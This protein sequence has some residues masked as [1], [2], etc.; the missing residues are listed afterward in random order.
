[1]YPLSMRRSMRLLDVSPRAVFPPRSGAGVRIYNLL[2][3]LGRR[4]EVRG[5]SHAWSGRLL[6]RPSVDEVR[7]SP[8]YREYRY[9]HPATRLAGEVAKGTWLG[10][11]PMSGIG[12]HVARPRCL[13]SLLEWAELTLVEFPWQF[14][15]CR[16][17]RPRG[18]LV[19]A[20]H[21]VERRKFPSWA[22]AAGASVSARPWLRYIEWAE[23]RAA[24]RAD[25]ILTVSDNDRREFVD[26]YGVDPDRVAEVPNGADTEALFPVGPEERARAK[27]ELGLPPRPTVIF[28]GSKMPPNEAGLDHVRQVSRLSDRFTFLV[29]GRVAEPAVDG[30][31]VCTGP[32]EDMSRYFRAAD[33]AVCPIRHGGGTKIKLL[34]SLASGLPTVAFRESLRGLKLRDGDHLLLA[35]SSE[36]AIVGALDRLLDEPALAERLGRSGAQVVAREYDWRRIA[37]R[38]ESRLAELVDGTRVAA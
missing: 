23:A 10:Q 29:V 28:A 30:S 5:F 18:P 15:H 13:A 22:A 20:S 17:L 12:V 16:R 6:A 2:R 26:G 31:L 32:V 1:M 37:D 4:H 9:S 27:T 11:P 36:A 3:H 14:E 24:A 25:L 7:L 19:L 38:L 35:E 21:N 8:G 34:E 33:L